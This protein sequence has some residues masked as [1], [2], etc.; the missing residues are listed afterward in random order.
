MQTILGLFGLAERKG[1]V[2]RAAG[3]REKSSFYF[4]KSADHS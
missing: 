2:S 3:A 4:L 1:A